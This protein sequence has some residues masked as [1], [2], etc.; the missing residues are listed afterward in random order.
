MAS[1]RGAIFRRFLVDDLKLTPKDPV[2]PEPPKPPEAPVEAAPAEALPGDEA[3]APVGSG[4]GADAS[5]QPIHRQLQITEDVT[6]IKGLDAGLYL[7]EAIVSSK[8]FS[9]LVGSGEKITLAPGTIPEVRF[10]QK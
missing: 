6:E 8:D 5:V 2:V 3:S 1:G 7:V 10:K 4:N 9:H